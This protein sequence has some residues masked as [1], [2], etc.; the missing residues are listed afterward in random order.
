[1]RGSSQQ[2]KRVVNTFPPDEH[3]KLMIRRALSIQE[4]DRIMARHRFYHEQYGRVI[5]KIGK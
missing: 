1:M 4:D 5:A 3:A 2:S